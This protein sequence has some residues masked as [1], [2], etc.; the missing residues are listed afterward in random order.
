MRIYED[1]TEDSNKIDVPA[2]REP[3]T[4][5]LYE[6]KLTCSGC[7]FKHCG[8]GFQVQVERGPKTRS[9][10]CI[11]YNKDGGSGFELLF[12]AAVDE[13]KFSAWNQAV[14]RAEELSARG[15]TL[16][17]ELKLQNINGHSDV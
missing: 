15:H 6:I 14:Q 13:A 10:N 4:K 2:I 11:N 5:V 12:D 9:L 1:E 8:H 17:S 16:L 3:T 7:A